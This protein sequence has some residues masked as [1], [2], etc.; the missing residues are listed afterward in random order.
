MR[1]RRR[2]SRNCC[3]R[4]NHRS[5]G[6][7]A[8]RTG[9]MRNLA[10]CFFYQAAAAERPQASPPPPLVAPTSSFVL[11]RWQSQRLA[12]SSSPPLPL[13]CRLRRR[14]QPCVLCVCG[15]KRELRSGVS[16]CLSKRCHVASS[17][18]TSNWVHCCLMGCVKPCF[19][20][21]LFVSHRHDE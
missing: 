15:V 19:I 9:G 14:G 1:G 10:W 11:H 5:R 20:E 2:H 6:R 21:V 7:T 16:C 8:H 12:R 13:L 17:S 18:W 4:R 3:W